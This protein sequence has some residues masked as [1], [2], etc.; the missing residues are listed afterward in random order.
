MRVNGGMRELKHWNKRPG[1]IQNPGQVSPVI[2]PRKDM[3]V[4]GQ[5]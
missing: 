4:E 2:S 5:V 1:R 3:G